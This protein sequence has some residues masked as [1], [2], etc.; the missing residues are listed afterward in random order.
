MIII[1]IVFSWLE[2]FK[3]KSNHP[4]SQFHLSPRSPKEI[5][6]MLSTLETWHC[7][8][9]GA[10]SHVLW[11]P[12]SSHTSHSLDS[13]SLDSLDS[14]DLLKTWPGHRWWQWAGSHRFLH[15]PGPQSTGFVAVQ[16]G[17]RRCKVPFQGPLVL[18]S[19]W[20]HGVFTPSCSLTFEIADRCASTIESIVE[21]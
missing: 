1:S 6:E 11:D 13:D 14:L 2:S 3:N 4:R 5:Q 15:L 10:R 8:L 19:N 7:G 17:L 18:H 21:V 20:Y 12:L 16:I 9:Q